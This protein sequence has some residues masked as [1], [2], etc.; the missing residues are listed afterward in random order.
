MHFQFLTIFKVINRQ[1][2]NKYLYLHMNFKCDKHFNYGWSRPNHM[3]PNYIFVSQAMWHVVHCLITRTRWLFICIHPNN[4][5]WN[6]KQII[7]FCICF[8]VITML[9]IY[10]LLACYKGGYFLLKI[11][12]TLLTKMAK[13]G[14]TIN[15]D[16]FL[17]WNFW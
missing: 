15:L 12:I 9:I 5:R 10:L 7:A 4:N 1:T 6:L 8:S 11:K 14:K 17:F 13:I 16:C 2:K 3:P